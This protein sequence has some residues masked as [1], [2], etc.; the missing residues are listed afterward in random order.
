L[1]G[2]N[3]IVGRSFFDDAGDRLLVTS[4]FTTLQ[5]EGP[6]QGQPSIF[7]RLTKCNLSCWFCDTTFE[8]GDYFSLMDLGEKAQSMILDKYDSLSK[9]G[10]VI[11]GGEPS[12]QP[13]ISEF[14]ATC[15]IAGTAFTQIES[16]GILPIKKLP[17]STTLVVSPKCSE[18]TNKYLMPHVETLERADCLK[19]VVNSDPKSPYHS[20]PDWAFEW[21]LKT[22]N[23]IYVSPMNTYKP[24]VLDAA[25]QRIKDRKEHNLE[26]RST[27]DE[28]VSGWDDTILDREQNRINHSYAATYAMNYGLFLT[29][30]MH[31][32]AQIA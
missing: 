31:L 22:D 4:I 12:L 7:I 26:Y 30:Q 5:G 24:A 11:T 2:Q 9:C 14:L 16:N 13:N 1:F 19:F 27:I 32:F 17:F 6:Y 15:V 8:S 20:I 21:Q 23:P 28:V 3:E 10:I 18:K 29:L 25:R